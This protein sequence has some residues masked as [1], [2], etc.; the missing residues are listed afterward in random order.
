MVAAVGKDGRGDGYLV[1]DDAAGG[2]AAGVDLGRDVFDDDA[3]ADVS[4][5]HDH[6]SAANLAVENLAA[7]ETSDGC[8]ERPKLAGESTRALE[9]QMQGHRGG[10]GCSDR[11]LDSKS[12]FGIYADFLR[13]VKGGPLLPPPTDGDLSPGTPERKK[14]VECVLSV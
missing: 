9:T 6:P 4:R 2:M 11:F 8:M 5:L 10:S 14:P 7:V 3:V 12:I 1:A 13:S